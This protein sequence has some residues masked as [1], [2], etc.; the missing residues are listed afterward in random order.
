MSTP[1]K[2]ILIRRSAGRVKPGQTVYPPLRSGSQRKWGKKG[3][4]TRAWKAVDVDDE[5]TLHIKRGNAHYWLSKNI[6]VLTLLSEDPIL[7]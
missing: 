2:P 1:P 6:V 3:H 4:T 7:G 5:G